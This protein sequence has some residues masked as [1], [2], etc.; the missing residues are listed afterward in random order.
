M[1]VNVRLSLNG[2]IFLFLFCLFVLLLGWCD[3]RSTQCNQR[4]SVF[5][6]LQIRHHGRHHPEKRER[7]KGGSECI[8]NVQRQGVAHRREIQRKLL[9]ITALAFHRLFWIYKTGAEME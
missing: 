3:L 1:I 4:I 6:R 8:G 5:W 7:K 9:K 2:S